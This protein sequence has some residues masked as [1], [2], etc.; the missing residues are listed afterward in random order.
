[1]IFLKTY[2]SD[3]SLINKENEVT[4]TYFYDKLYLLKK[5]NQFRVFTHIG[6]K[7]ENEDLD[8]LSEWIKSVRCISKSRIK[9]L[10]G[11]MKTIYPSVF[12][13]AILV[14]ADKAG[15]HIVFVC[16]AY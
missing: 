12:N 9:R 15:N 8:T 5:A 13:K 10:R 3:K 14:P 11:Q 7:F 2:I 6:K 4:K 16:M 1:M